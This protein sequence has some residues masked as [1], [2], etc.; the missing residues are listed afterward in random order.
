MMSRSTPAAPL[1]EVHDASQ[2]RRIRSSWASEKLSRQTVVLF[3]WFVV[4][5]V[6]IAAYGI[7]RGGWVDELGFQNPPYMLAHFGKLTFPSYVAGWFFDQPVITHPPIH[8]FLIGLLCR[9]GLTIYYAEATPTVLLFLLAILCIVRS[10]FP[11]AVKLGLLFSIGYIMA[12]AN[13][14]PWADLFGTRPEGHVHAAWLS[15]LVLLESG[16]LDNWNWR[17]LGAGAFLLTWASGTHYYAVFAFTGV[18][19]YALWAIRSLSWKDAKPRL[20]ALILGG[21]LF[22]I[23]YVL[24]YLLP[25]RRAI[26]FAVGV[27]PGE[28][29]LRASMHWHAEMYRNWIALASHMA[30]A[31]KVMSW[32]VPLLV[33]TTAILASVRWTRGLAL[34]ALPLQLFLYLFA[35]HKLSQYLVHEVALFA[36]AVAI[37]AL[38][39]LARFTAWLPARI[40]PGV[41]PVAAALMAI[42]LAAGSPVLKVATLSLE[43]RVHGSEVARAVAREI[44]GPNARVGGD[45]GQWYASGADHFYDTQADIQLGYMGYDPRTYASNLDALVDCPDSCVG[46]DKTSITGWFAD[47]T[48]KLRGF[49]MGET[50]DQ[51]QIALLSV[52]QPVQ[53][54]GY[55]SRDGQLYRFQ[56]EAEGSYDA[57]SAVC[58]QS[59]ELGLNKWGW[60]KYWPNVFLTVL[61]VPE[62][63]PDAGRVVVTLLTPRAVAEPASWMGRNC[64]ALSRVPGT[65]LLADRK[66]MVEKLRRTDSPMHFYRSFEQMP[67][68]KGVGLPASELPPDQANR[69][70]DVLDLSQ[71][72]LWNG[73]QMD[74]GPDRRLNT[75]P[76]MGAFCASIP[77]HHADSVR[78]PCWVQLRLR[79]LSGRVGFQVFNTNH[80]TLLQTLPI[81]AAGDPQTIALR[82]PDFRSATNIIITNESR[83]SGQVEVL[84]A[85]ILV[86]R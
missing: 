44:L 5:L 51:L 68:Y 77:V 64:R 33:Y 55:A 59:P 43:P 28:G 35:W 56:Q 82:V 53:L 12:A 79:V 74:A 26:Q 13:S 22:G 6:L 50:N 10:V 36:G 2:L 75:L 16:R 9:L 40:Q 30:L 27:T 39:V 70:D 18:A 72:Q 23:P 24:L 14:M 80:G 49:Y 11:D 37:G 81:G 4:F 84:D 25:Y 83:F 32:G 20:A 67:G 1:H 3:A 58:P 17:S 69:V 66:A 7:D 57:I 29:S 85:S 52:R 34:A 41:L 73:A 60:Y 71:M 8:T 42:H 76:H 19:V 54:L 65:V 15:G 45:W 63:S 47:G 48:L 62:T 78:G 46:P 31:L 86:A 38:V 61:E 21:C